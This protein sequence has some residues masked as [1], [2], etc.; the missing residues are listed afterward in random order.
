M[1]SAPLRVAHCALRATEKEWASVPS[2]S[3]RPFW[4]FGSVGSCGLARPPCEGLS[5]LQQFNVEILWHLA[6][7]LFESRA[8]SNCQRCDESGFLAR[9]AS[10]S[11]RD[12]APGR[13]VQL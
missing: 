7:A 12:P 13:V 3:A 10:A 8:K 2:G 9:S 6:L 4:V 1:R 11:H 5:G